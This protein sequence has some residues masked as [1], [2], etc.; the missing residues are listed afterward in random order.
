[1]RRCLFIIV[2]LLS[3]GG[4][5]LAGSEKF[6]LPAS[7]RIKTNIDF[8]WRYYRGDVSGEEET[9]QVNQRP[10]IN[11]NLPHEWS[12][13]GPY[14][15]ENNLTNAFLPMEIGWY[16]KGLMLPHDY[17]DKQLYLVFDGVYRESDVWMNYYHLGHHSSGYTSF[18]Y[19]I[20]HYV[21]TGNQTPNGI[22]VRVDG[23][24]HEQDAYEGTGIYRHVWLVAVNKL[25]IAN[26][27]TFV[28]TPNVT[29]KVANIKVQTRLRNAGKVAR[30]FNLITKIVDANGHV[31]AEISSKHELQAGSEKE[32]VQTT[33]VNK[34]HRWDV[35]DPYLYKAYSIVEEDNEIID[36]FATPFGIRTFYFDAN[37][38]FFLNGRHLKLK[39][40]NEHHDFAGL[41][42]ALPDRIHWNAMM[43]MKKAGFNFF[44][45][46]HNPATPERLDVCDEIGMLVWNEIDRKLVKKE[47]LLPKV[48]ET[49]VRDR[50]HPSVILWA[51]E[52]ES[53]LESTVYGAECMKA[54]TDL[55]H[56]LDP[57]RPTTFAPSMPVSGNG[58]GDAVG[59]VAYNYNW[60][61]ADR[62]H[63]ENPEWKMMGISE[64]AAKRCR[65]GVYGIE[66]FAR[67]END[68]YFDLYDGEIK[69][70]Y[71]MCKSVEG[72]W[73]RINAREYMGGGCIWSGMDYW[74]SG[75]I[76]PLNSRSDGL[77][78]L[79]FFPKD[80]YYYFVSQWVKE[81]MLHIFPHWNW[82]NSNNKEVKV[83]SYSNCDEVE[84]FLNGRSLGT[85]KRPKQP[86]AWDPKSYKK[87]N[88]NTKKY[89]LFEGK[90]FV[91]E[92]PQHLVWT[93]PFEA[94][95]LRAE[96][97]NK[98]K[99]VYKK[100][101]Q[102]SW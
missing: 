56:E 34:P 65:R 55:A 36:T 66:H 13:E 62:D 70:V 22:R 1:M 40:F 64:Y 29:D 96:G 3:I 20:T 93:V 76:W 54:G 99:V 30:Q 67:A 59:V 16:R 47:I 48:R 100:E 12:M 49:I 2:M 26:W 25:H 14:N 4:T 73:M 39:G 90:T 7:D 52:N 35:D 102:N 87:E 60:P 84:L 81:P 5:L 8:G 63:M 71:E 101:N 11:V 92:Y 19:D 58:Y 31:V 91:E 43:S 10:W 86:P 9:H 78:D 38:G 28:S 32:F 98:G 85:Q 33:E 95:T 23:R 79:C 77:L 75:D 72:Y 17:K 69:N 18:V 68:N 42:R 50:N 37:K 24:R 46:S 41:G 74:G 57:T 97:R 94:G 53:P 80:S 15:H 44:R 83:W 82:E 88:T 21:R 51:L 6:T 45:A 27:G 89:R 61:R